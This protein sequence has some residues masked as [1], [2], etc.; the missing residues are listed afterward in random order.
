MSAPSSLGWNGYPLCDWLSKHEGWNRSEGAS[1]LSWLVQGL[2]SHVTKALEE[3]REEMHSF[4]PKFGYRSNK[5]AQLISDPN[6]RIGQGE[7]AHLVEHQ[8]R[9]LIQLKV[10]S[11][12]AAGSLNTP[13]AQPELDTPG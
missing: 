6:L 8:R 9:L 7:D 3:L 10:K 4:S 5:G 2:R 11:V 12:N 13:A 1:V